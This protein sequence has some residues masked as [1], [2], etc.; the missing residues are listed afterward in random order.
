[1]SKHGKHRRTLPSPDTYHPSA[2]RGALG[3]RFVHAVMADFERY[4]PSQIRRLRRR[5]P[6]EYLR[7]VAALLPKEYRIKEVAVPELPEI[8][9]EELSTMF[10]K[11]KELIALDREGQQYVAALEAADAASAASA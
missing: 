6:T 9:D 2:A 4:G 1:M 8:S 3:Q 10:N 5:R 7:L 11:V